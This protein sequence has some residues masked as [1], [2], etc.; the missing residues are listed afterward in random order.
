MN[1]PRLVSSFTLLWFAAALVNPDASLLPDPIS[2]PQTEKIFAD[3]G[4]ALE[5]TGHTTAPEGVRDDPQ[6]A[7]VIASDCRSLSLAP[8]RGSLGFIDALGCCRL[9]MTP[10]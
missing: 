10:R 4:L 6:D 1:I 8:D 9:A 7:Q 3:L 5:H 2:S